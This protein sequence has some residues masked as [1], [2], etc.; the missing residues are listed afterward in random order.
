MISIGKKSILKPSYKPL[1]ITGGLIALVLLAIYLIGNYSVNRYKEQ[2]AEIDEAQVVANT[3]EE[4]F[5]ELDSVKN[6]IQEQ[7]AVASL[8]IPGK[9]PALSMLVVV[10]SLANENSVDISDLTVAGGAGEDTKTANVSI[11]VE[12]EFASVVNFTKEIKTYYPLSTIG[13]I[14]A[15]LADNQASVDVS[16]SGYYAD[17]PKTLPNVSS[18]ID[19]LTTEDYDTILQLSGLKKPPV[20][21][22]LTPSLTTPRSNP[23]SL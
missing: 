19:K 10:K 21:T 14:D 5:N 22:S 11:G 4:K 15:S 20:I 9:S 3:L 6:Q 2:T 17:L 16:V 23:F 18:P 1:I 13:E 7:A 8:G 12:G